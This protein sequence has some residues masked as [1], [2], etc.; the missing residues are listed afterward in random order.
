MDNEEI[1]FQ[2]INVDE[3]LIDETLPKGGW[4]RVWIMFQG[5]GKQK[6]LE[7]GRTLFLRREFMGEGGLPLDMQGPQSPG[8]WYYCWETVLTGYL[9]QRLATYWPLVPKVSWRFGVFLP[10]ASHPTP[11]A[12][13]FVGGLPAP[14]CSGI[15]LPHSHQP[16]LLFSLPSSWRCFPG[17]SCHTVEKGQSSV[18][19]RPHYF[20]CY[21]RPLTLAETPS[22]QM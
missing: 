4:C 10:P 16:C 19:S 8:V 21:L 14:C 11:W 17:R 2:G 1:I 7:G 20:L 22:S 6:A 5:S 18:E 12:A 15:C 3:R 9:V 13:A